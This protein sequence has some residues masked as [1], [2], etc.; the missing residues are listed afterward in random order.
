MHVTRFDEA[1]TYDAP[2]HHD[3]TA[4]R[5]QGEEA[6]PAEIATVGLSHFHHHRGEIVGICH[7]ASG[8]GAH[9]AFSLATQEELFAKLFKAWMFRRLNHRYI[10][11]IF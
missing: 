4:L 8:F 2:R 6:S 3:V 9:H 10:F 7:Q 5:L 11:Q 1:N